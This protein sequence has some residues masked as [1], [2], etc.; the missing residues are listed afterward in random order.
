MPSARQNEMPAWAKSRHTPPPLRS[1]TSTLRPRRRKVTSSA[2]RGRHDAGDAVLDV[3]VD[4][5]ADGCYVL[6]AARRVAEQLPGAI[7]ERVGLA[8]TAGEQ[9]LQELGRKL[10]DAMLDIAVA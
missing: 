4:P 9:P 8:Q 3:A 1:S 10:L 2:D 5:I 6:G 7:R